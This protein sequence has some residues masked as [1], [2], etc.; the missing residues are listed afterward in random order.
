[1]PTPMYDGIA[2]PE[3]SVREKS[4]LLRAV[5]LWM[6]VGLLLTALTSWFTLSSPGLLQAIMTNQL[7]FFGLMI[8][9]LILVVA[10]T[11][12]INRLAA[13]TATLLFL[14]YS[15]INGLTLSFIFLV[16]TQGSIMQAFLSAACMFASMSLYGYF[17]NR[18]LTSIGS[19]CVM[20]LLGLIAATVINLIFFHSTGADL[21][22]S[23]VGVLIF[24]G[25]TA[26][27]TQKIVRQGASLKEAGRE[28]FLKAAVLGA[29]A[30]YL[31][32]INMF[33]YLLRLFGKRR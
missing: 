33:L 10:I 27:D 8:G 20:G 11:A 13:S 1:M 16:Y 18:D 23:A 5:Y 4:E 28:M 30:L 29:L 21:L 15:A 3:A 7:L 32:F 19:Y 26:Y 17:T 24:M 2:Y 12:G 9:E 22:I 14:V 31:D 6:F 25:L